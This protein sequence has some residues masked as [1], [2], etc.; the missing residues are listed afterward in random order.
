MKYFSMFAGIGGFEKGIEQATNNT[1]EC[2]GYS[3]IDK[4]A[5]SI[6]QKHF[7]G[8]KNYGD[9]TRIN[10]STLPDFDILVG[11]FPCQ[12]F[13]I[14]GQRKGFDDTRGTLFFEVARILRDKRPRYFLL[15]NVKGLLS[16][17]NGKTYH[18]ILRVLSDLGYNIEW[19]VLNSKDF[20]VPQNRERI[21]IFGTRE[22]SRPKI[23]PIGTS[24][25]TDYVVPTLTARYANASNGAYLRQ[26]SPQGGSQGMRVYDSEGLATT[27]ASQTGGLGAKTGLY[28]M[29][30]RKGE[31][32]LEKRKDENTNTL[33]SVQK[34][35]YII[36]ENLN[37]KHRI[38]RLTP[39]ECERLQ[40]FP[41]NWTKY[42]N[43]NKLISDS[44]RYK[45]LGNAV[46]VNVI[47]SIIR[48][49]QQAK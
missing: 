4:Y 35:N 25:K 11:G 32:Q 1:W 37:L 30:G 10:T 34:D 7:K 13:S 12:A 19:Q 40:A 42:G 16:H 26:I 48:K 39:V 18:T 36:S 27:I 20:G 29:R 21:F 9:T 43:D 5:I 2:V 17:N 23:F 45:C 38:R 49:I 46:T 33:T 28:A 14:A 44:Q 24:S 22:R 47:E 3:E 6:Y 8:H 31:Q 15:E 41:D